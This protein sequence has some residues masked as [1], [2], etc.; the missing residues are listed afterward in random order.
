MRARLRSLL[1]GLLHRGDVESELDEELRFH[2]ARRAD[3]LARAGLPRAAAERQARLE[4]GAVDAVKDRCREARGLRFADELA[5]DLRYAVRLLGKDR[6]FTAAAVLTLALGAGANSALFSLCDAVLL[7]PLPYPRP[8]ELVRVGHTLPKGALAVLRR[9]G[10]ALSAVAAYD[11]GQELNLTGAGAPERLLGS[12]VSPELFAVLGARAALGRTLR[13][14]ED[15]PGADGVVVLADGCW[16]ERFG[17]D[18]A[19]VGRRLT[20]DGTVREVVGVMPPGFAFPSADTRLWVPARIDRH[21]PVDL[22]KR[23]VGFVGRLAPGVSAAQADGELRRLLPHV[24]D[25]FPW[26]MPRDWKEGPE[27]RV[28]PLREWMVGDV[29]PRLLVLWAAVWLVLLV[30]CADVANLLLARA[31]V[32]ER[33]IALR[34]AL[35]GGRR[36][37][38]RQLL[39]E[40]LVLSLAG[41]AAGLALAAAGVPLL[42]AL[43]PA[44]TPRLAE[45]TLDARTF[46]F[47]TALALATGVACGLLPALRAVGPAEGDLGLRPALAAREGATGG[48]GRRRASAA[49]VVAVVALSVV[50]V[51]GAGLLVRTLDQLLRVSPGFRSAQLLTARIT[52]DDSI[53]APPAAA[54]STA[55]SS[56]GSRPSPA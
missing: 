11:A 38:L 41:G 39:T 4:L 5:Q 42:V 17:A 9:E 21:D 24:R 8:A 49:L 14:G 44:G 53:C 26:R 35:G 3:D 36:R 22:W 2:L 13:A 54:T 50:L 23:E 48:R 33:E 18:P 47:A 29:R 45:A 37:I 43:L 19:V 20:V 16:R 46:A 10:R 30:A 52:P 7:K 6:G 1:R 34:T 28:V 25:A 56:R 32:R 31:A 40:S 27:N 51:T 12:R 15:A 55:R